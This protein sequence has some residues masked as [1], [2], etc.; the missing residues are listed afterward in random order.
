MEYWMNR[1]K[2]DFK[3]KQDPGKMLE[4]QLKRE[5]VERNRKI[6]GFGDRI[7]LESLGDR[8]TTTF[9]LKSRTPKN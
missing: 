2:T 1:V 8:T 6:E 7:S 3:P 9:T 5:E 4:L